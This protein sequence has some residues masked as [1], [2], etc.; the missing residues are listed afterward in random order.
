MAR[1]FRTIPS[2]GRVQIAMSGRS[3]DQ[4]SDAHLVRQDPDGRHFVLIRSGR[5]HRT[6]AV[7][8]VETKQLLRYL[9]N[10]EWTMQYSDDD[11]L[12]SWS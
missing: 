2:L 3:L 5:S 7:T 12:E 10:F 9:S 1:T 4:R 8:S 11:D 6:L